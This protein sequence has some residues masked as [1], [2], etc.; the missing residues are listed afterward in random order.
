MGPRLPL[1]YRSIVEMEAVDLEYDMV[2]AVSKPAQGPR[3]CD[4]IADLLLVTKPAQGLG[5]CDWYTTELNSV[6]KPSWGLRTRDT[7][8]GRVPSWHDPRNF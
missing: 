1:R 3:S 4:A 8:E 6:S 2:G 5:S 7:A